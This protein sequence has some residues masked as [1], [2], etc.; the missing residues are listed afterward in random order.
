[1][2][3]CLGPV[4]VNMYRSTL[5]CETSEFRLIEIVSINVIQHAATPKLGVRPCD[6]E[7]FA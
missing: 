6:I 7:V 3:F 2:L 4:H 5:G 1:L